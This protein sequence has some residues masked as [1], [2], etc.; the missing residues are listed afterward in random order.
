MLETCPHCPYF[1]YP[2]PNPVE[3]SCSSCGSSTPAV[4]VVGI[5]HCMSY[6]IFEFSLWHLKEFLLFS[7]KEQVMHPKT[8]ILSHVHVCTSI[9]HAYKHTCIPTNRYLEA[10]VPVSPAR[11]LI[12][13]DCSFCECCWGILTF[14]SQLSNSWLVRYN[15]LSDVSFD[16]LE[17]QLKKVFRVLIRYCFCWFQKAER[18]ITIV[19]SLTLHEPKH[20][21]SFLPPF[22]YIKYPTYIFYVW[23]HA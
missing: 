23:K 2:P 4:W 13:W 20:L 8:Q 5:G 19:C 3:I 16:I 21:Q 1:L 15:I 22:A 18:N 10:I 17:I 6:W 14:I 9:Q 12:H 11:H 7:Q